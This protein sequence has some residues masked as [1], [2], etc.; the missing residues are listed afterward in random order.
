M[1]KHLK[2]VENQELEKVDVTEEIDET[3]YVDDI[4]EGGLTVGKA[5]QLKE[6]SADVFCY[7]KIEI[8]ELEDLSNNSKDQTYAKQKLSVN[9]N[10]TKILGLHWN[11]I[12][13]EIG[14]VFPEKDKS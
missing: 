6:T 12:T 8:H 9:A 10:E 13:D 7:G 3:L 2:L 14:I 11:K 4:I 1:K 5:K